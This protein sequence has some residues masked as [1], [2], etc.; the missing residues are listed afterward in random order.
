MTNPWLS[1]TCVVVFVVVVAKGD[2]VATV[3]MYVG[4]ASEDAGTP[5][6]SPPPPP[7]VAVATVVGTDPIPDTGVVVEVGV[8]DAALLLVVVLDGITLVRTRRC[9]F[10]DDDRDGA[11][12][13]AIPPF[14][15][16]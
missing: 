9:G 10:L 2:E 16:A 6:L 14:A 7:L 5:F 4:S 13:L 8:D 1:F 12:V 15:K 3:L 11:A